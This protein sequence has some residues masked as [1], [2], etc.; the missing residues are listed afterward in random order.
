MIGG[1]VRLLAARRIAEMLAQLATEH[2]LYQGLLQPAGRR[3]D[4]LHRHPRRVMGP[5]H[6][7]PT[8]KILDTLQRFSFSS[9]V[10]KKHAFLQLSSRPFT[11][12]C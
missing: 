9:T 11:P 2:P 12:S 6:A 10:E 4:V 1:V 7:S 3:V 5:P 8:H